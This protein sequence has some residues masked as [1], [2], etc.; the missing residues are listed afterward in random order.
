MRT[1]SIGRIMQDV[2]AMLSGSRGGTRRA[3][4]G[5]RGRNRAWGARSRRS[6]PAGRSGLGS[7]V[8]RFLR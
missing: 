6:T 7:I 1:S 2:G 4:T 8:S 3:G 5:T